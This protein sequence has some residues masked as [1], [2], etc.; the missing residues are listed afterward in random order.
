MLRLVEIKNSVAI[1]IKALR[2]ETWC[3]V[4]MQEETRSMQ[5][6]C[7]MQ[8]RNKVYAIPMQKKLLD[9]VAWIREDKKWR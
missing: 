7:K 5:L 2:D 4:E 3:G 6:T 1:V 9:E 8:A